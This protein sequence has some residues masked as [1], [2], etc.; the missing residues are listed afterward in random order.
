MPCTRQSLRGSRITL[1]FGIAS[2]KGN[3]VSMVVQKQGF[4]GFFDI[5]SCGVIAPATILIHL[6]SKKNIF[7]GGIDEM[8]SRHVDHV[9]TY[10]LQ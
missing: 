2:L 1:G 7:I 10:I 3:L 8:I 4:S 6:E 9:R 5:R